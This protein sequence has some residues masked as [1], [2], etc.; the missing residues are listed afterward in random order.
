MDHA[1]HRFGADAADTLESFGLRS[2]HDIGKVVF[3][4]VAVGFLKAEESDRLEDFDGVLN[5]RAALSQSAVRAND[6]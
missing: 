6:G 1:R 2:S 5:V 4:L 3:G